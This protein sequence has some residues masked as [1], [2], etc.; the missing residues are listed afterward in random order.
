[1]TAECIWIWVLTPESML[2]SESTVITK[3][4]EILTQLTTN[5]CPN[6]SEA[7]YLYHWTRN[8]RFINH[9]LFSFKENGQCETRS[10]GILSCQPVPSSSACYSCLSNTCLRSQHVTA[11]CPTCVYVHSMLQL[12]VQH[13]FTFTACYSCLSNMYLR[14]QHVTAVCPTCVYVHCIRIVNNANTAVCCSRRK[15]SLFRDQPAEPEPVSGAS[16]V[17]RHLHPPIIMKLIS[18]IMCYSFCVQQFLQQMEHELGR[19]LMDVD[20]RG[21]LLRLSFTT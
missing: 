6:D 19:Q 12:S 4:F 2:H 10:R 20:S 7:P 16:C 18:T 5:Q 9:V 3:S 15:W 17:Q 11:V 21:E 1:M 13:V 8:Y 14:S